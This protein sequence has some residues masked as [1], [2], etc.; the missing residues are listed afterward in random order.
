MMDRRGKLVDQ[1][2]HALEAL[3]IV[4]AYSFAAPAFLFDDLPVFIDD[5]FGG[6]SG[7]GGAGNREDC[8]RAACEH[9]EHAT[10]AGHGSR[11]GGRQTTAPTTKTAAN[12][13]A[14]NP[15]NARNDCITDRTADSRSKK[16]FS[17]IFYRPEN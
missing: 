8:A 5:I 4:R 17:D 15:A 9:G 6:S 10:G 12:G 3:E 1:S 2:R 13:G 11:K 14:N 16:R 7:C